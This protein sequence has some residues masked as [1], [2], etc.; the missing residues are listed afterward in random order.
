MNNFHDKYAKLEKVAEGTYGIVFKGKNKLTNK[1]CSIKKF[2]N[3][4][5]EGIPV[6]GVR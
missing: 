2:K 1:L 3:V 6:S 4:S 5:K